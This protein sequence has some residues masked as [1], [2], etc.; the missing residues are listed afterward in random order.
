[1]FHLQR[2]LKNKSLPSDF[3]WATTPCKVSQRTIW[4]EDIR[5]VF[6]ACKCLAVLWDCWH[7]NCS[8]WTALEPHVSFCRPYNDDIVL[9]KYVDKCLTLAFSRW[10]ST[11]DAQI[12]CHEAFDGGDMSLESEAGDHF[13]KTIAFSHHGRLTYKNLCFAFRACHH[14]PHLFSSFITPHE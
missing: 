6:Q 2:I 8:Y 9:L 7:G 12:P 3:P 10:L 13:M 11:P 1:M 14:S 4:T 5:P